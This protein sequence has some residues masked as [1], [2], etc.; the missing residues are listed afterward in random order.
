MISS[1]ETGC[2]WSKFNY[3]FLDTYSAV[4]Q[5]IHKVKTGKVFTHHM[6]SP[7]AGQAHSTFHTEVRSAPEYY[8]HR[9]PE[10]VPYLLRSGE[11]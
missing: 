11:M 7:V 4:Q 6:T 5:C 10:L 3:I 2:F 8:L 9:D 1:F